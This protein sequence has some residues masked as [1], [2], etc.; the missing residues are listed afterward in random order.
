MEKLLVKYSLQNAE[1]YLKTCLGDAGPEVVN[2][3]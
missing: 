3:I 2:Y 1:Y